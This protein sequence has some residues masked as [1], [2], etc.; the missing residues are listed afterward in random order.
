MFGLVRGSC[1]VSRPRWSWCSGWALRRP[2]TGGSDQGTP[3]VRACT[4]PTAPP[5]GTGGRADL[6]PGGGGLRVVDQG[7]TQHESDRSR[8]SVGAVVENPAYVTMTEVMVTLGAVRWVTPDDV[9]GAVSAQAI[10]MTRTADSPLSAD[11]GYTRRSR[12]CRALT[13]R[14]VGMVFR[15]AAGT[16]VG[17]SLVGVEAD[18]CAPG[19]ADD[20]LTVVLSLPASADLAKTE[21]ALYCDLAAAPKPTAS[22]DPVN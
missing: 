21:L 15:N 5:V 22:D 14:G 7:F 8:V 4:E 1:A 3:Q 16:I 19:A 13:P 20:H 12:A 17:G 2:A 11:V 10:T 9:P 18:T 6:A